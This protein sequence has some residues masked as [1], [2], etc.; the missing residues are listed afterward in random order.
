MMDTRMI[1]ALR[2]MF[3]AVI[4]EAENNEDFAS[5]L[6]RAFTGNPSSKIKKERVRRRQKPVLNP[7]DMIEDMNVLDA[8]LRALSVDQLKDIV[9][10]YSMD[11][12]RR[13]LQW[14]KPERLIALIL[15]VSQKRLAK[16]NAF[17][18]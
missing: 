16:G 2:S 4:D 9:S 7:L 11:P 17:R 13:A 14:R 6:E 8:K 1:T 5:K 10:V 3:D 18:E 15:D 12:S